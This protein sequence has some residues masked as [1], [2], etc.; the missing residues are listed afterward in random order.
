MIVEHLIALNNFYVN[1]TIIYVKLHKMAT[2]LRKQNLVKRQEEANI[3]S[4]NKSI[5]FQ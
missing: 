4:A 2:Y 3:A 5:I 1:N